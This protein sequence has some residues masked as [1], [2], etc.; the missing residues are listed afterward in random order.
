M[1]KQQLLEQQARWAERLMKYQFSIV[2]QLGSKNVVAN[3]LSQREQDTFRRKDHYSQNRQLIPQ[4]ALT[5]WP[6]AAPSATGTK[7]LPF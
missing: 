7:D 5:E 2:Y 1:K 3:A 6:Q 4:E